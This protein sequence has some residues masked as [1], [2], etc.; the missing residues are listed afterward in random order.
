[1]ADVREYGR[2]WCQ[3]HFSGRAPF[4]PARRLFGHPAG[5]TAR[6]LACRDDS[7]VRRIEQST[8]RLKDTV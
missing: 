1:M 2:I 5:Q 7:A 8:P 6:A 4:Q 3:I